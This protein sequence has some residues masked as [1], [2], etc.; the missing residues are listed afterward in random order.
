MEKSKLEKRKITVGLI[1]C[2]FFGVIFLIT[3]LGTLAQ[4]SYF[5]GIIIIVGSL[6]LIPYFEDLI[7][8][9]FNFEFSTGVR[10]LISIVILVFFFIGMSTSSVNDIYYESTANNAVSNGEVTTKV[11]AKPKPITYLSVTYQDLE[12][13]FGINSKY[14]DLQKEEKFNN[15]YHG[16]YVKW[17]GE[18]MEVDTSWGAL[19][20]TIKHKNRDFDFFETGDVTVNMNEDQRNTLLEIHKGDVVTYSGRLNDYSGSH[21]YLNDG[22]IIT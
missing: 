15:E 11:I 20:L 3:G 2:W 10:W 5:S 13:I 14:T 18:V 17:T 12:F 19:K 22:W 4:G 21:F 7:S 16:K 6:L 9:K 8:K 1:A